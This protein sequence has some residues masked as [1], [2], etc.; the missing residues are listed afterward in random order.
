[1]RLLLVRASLQ[2]H[3]TRTL[4]AILGVA[5][6]MA[7]LLDMVMLSTGMRESFRRMLESRGFQI[8]L[9]PKGTLPFDTDATITG[10][11]DIFTILRANPTVELVSPVLG[12]TVHVPARGRSISAF[13][14]GVIPSQQGDYALVAGSDALA[15]N[16]VVANDDFLRATGARIGDTV[17]VASGYDTELRAD[18]ATRKMIVA[19]RAR[20]LYL[21][22]G[23]LAIAMPLATLQAM[24]G[25]ADA[26]RVSLFMV[27][28][29]SDAAVQA[30]SRWITARVP[31]V[32]VISTET[33]LRRWMSGSATSGSSRSSSAP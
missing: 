11:S 32:T 16:R 25:P 4:L 31:R 26:D 33:A 10:A 19:G 13:A 2:R 22:A 8:R 1:M 7:M 18:V 3:S 20:F 28:A 12:A 17:N 9:S 21:A 23:Q 30:L 5:V 6:A 15:T 27:K 29:R 14:L 24:E